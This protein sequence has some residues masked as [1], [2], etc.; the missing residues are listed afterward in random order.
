[1]QRTAF[2]TPIIRQLL[3]GLGWLMLRLSGWRVDGELPAGLK[4]A[5]IIGAPHTS[6]WDFPLAMAAMFVRQ[7]P[8]YWV[9]KHTLFAGP[10]GPMMRFL[11]GLALDRSQAS[12]TVQAY[13]QLFE[14]H[15]E[16]MIMIAPE[17]TRKASPWRTGFYHIAHSAKVPIVLGYID[18]GSKTLGLGQVLY[19]SGDYQADQQQL[20]DFYQ[21]QQG[22]VPDNFK[23]P[24]AF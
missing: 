20:V 8:F 17:G 23:L 9:G 18:K 16:L 4:Q 7:W 22:L 13:A 24:G 12:N 3:K 15:P 14:Q 11:G 6:N 19:P 2:R 5:I 1:M 21:Q 10:A